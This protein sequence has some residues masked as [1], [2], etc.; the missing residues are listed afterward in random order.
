[1]NSVLW[2]PIDVGELDFAHR[3]VMSP[4]ARSRSTPDGTPTE[5]NGNYYAIISERTQPS[6]DGQEYVLTPGIYTD[7]YIA[8]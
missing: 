2:Q 6:D 7:D 8:G 4:M 1:M 5:M 3:L